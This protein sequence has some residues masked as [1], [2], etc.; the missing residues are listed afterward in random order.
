MPICR[1][2]GKNMISDILWDIKKLYMTI[3][4]NKAKIEAVYNISNDLY[5]VHLL[6]HHCKGNIY[7]YLSSR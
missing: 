7:A 3:L 2:N 4:R 1:I 6:L 5:V